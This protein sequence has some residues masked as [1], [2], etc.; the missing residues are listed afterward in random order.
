VKRTLFTAEQ[1]IN[2]PPETVFLILCDVERWP[3]WTST[4]VSVQRLEHRAFGIGAKARVLQPKLRPAVWQ[5][6]E[7]AKNR[8][9]TWVART[10]GLK[11]TAGHWIEAKGAGS[12]VSLTFEFSGFLSGMASRLYR[13]LIGQYLDTEAQGLKRRS[14]ASAAAPMAA[15]AA[16]PAAAP[17][18][19]R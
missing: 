8:S 11:M 12:R 5:V 6:T 17:K 1:D 7:L 4:M 13:R 15:P 10:V 9:F 18:D 3:E 19:A 16:A 14:E 2:A